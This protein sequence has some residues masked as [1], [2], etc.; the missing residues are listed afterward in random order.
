MHRHSDDTGQDAGH[1]G[2]AADATAHALL[3]ALIRALLAITRHA[4][5][6]VGLHACGMLNRRGHSARNPTGSESHGQRHQPQHQDQQKT[7]GL[8]KGICHVVRLTARDRGG[9]TVI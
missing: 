2:A 1:A 9:K 6:L 8:S 7:N 5:C 3:A 4:V